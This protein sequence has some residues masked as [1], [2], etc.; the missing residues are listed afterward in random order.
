MFSS[1]LVLLFAFAYLNNA[2]KNYSVQFSYAQGDTTCSSYVGFV[3]TAV[4]DCNSFYFRN[5]S[6]S[7]AVCASATCQQTIPA[8]PPG[9]VVTARYDNADCTGDVSSYIAISSGACNYKGNNQS[10]RIDCAGSFSQTDYDTSDCSGTGTVVIPS[11]PFEGS[12]CQAGFYL[13]CA[14]K[15]FHKEST[16]TIGDKQFSYD[17]LKKSDSP[18]AIPHEFKANG[19]KITTTCPGVLRVTPEHLVMTPSGFVMAGHLKTGDQLFS[20]IH[21]EKADCTI[22]DVQAD[23]DGQ[24]FGLNCETGHVVSDG[25]WVSTFGYNHNIPAAWMRFGSKIFG[26]KTASRIGDSVANLLQ[27]FGLL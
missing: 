16:I 27:R 6:C 19:L 15:C 14:L 13:A 9:A 22:T 1:V 11:T 2:V 20:E 8:D 26:V 17:D 10:T 4:T 7:G 25:Y 23:V 5:C 21:A 3:L 12:V 18:C 24:Y